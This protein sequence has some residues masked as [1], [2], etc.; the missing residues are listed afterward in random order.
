M[1][2]YDTTPGDGTATKNTFQGNG[3]QVS[4]DVLFVKHNTSGGVVALYNEGQDGLA[5]VAHNGDGTNADHARVDLVFQSQGQG[6]VLQQLILPFGAFQTA[7]SANGNK[8][9]PD[10]W[11]R[12]IMDLVIVGDTFTITGTFKN[13]SDPNNPNSALGSTITVIT[14]TGSLS[15]PDNPA[16]LHLNNPGEVGLVALGNESIDFPDNIGIS[17]T[18]F[19][20]TTVPEPKS[21]LLLA[22]LAALMVVVRRRTANQC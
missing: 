1:S 3:L 6:T 7:A 15:D 8:T 10:F 20:V 13:H 4:A 2:I 22:M 19:G 5:L 18:N 11:Y 12:V 9:G 21:V 17:L 16:T 14:F